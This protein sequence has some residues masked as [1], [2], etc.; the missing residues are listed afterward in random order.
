MKKNKLSELREN[1]K[2]CF[3]KIISLKEYNS[4]K[5]TNYLLSTKANRDRLNK[6]IQEMQESK[7]VKFD[8]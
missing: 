5:E 6:S 7:T 3:N 2:N 1:L 8:I 4:I